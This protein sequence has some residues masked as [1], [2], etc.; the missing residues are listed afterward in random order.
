MNDYRKQLEQPGGSV[1][2]LRNRFDAAA[3][4]GTAGDVNGIISLLKANIE[5]PDQ[6]EAVAG[7]TYTLARTYNQDPLTIL[8][9]LDGW[10]ARYNG[11]I[12]PKKTAWQQIKDGAVSG[13]YTDQLGLYG[14]ALMDDYRSPEEKQMYKDKIAE[15]KA[16]MP[17]TAGDSKNL[18]VKTFTSTANLLGTMA[19]PL[20]TN[21]AVSTLIPAAKLPI[22]AAQLGK[23]IPAIAVKVAGHAISFGTTWAV[24]SEVEAGNIYIDMLE[25]GVDEDI[26]KKYANIHGAIAGALEAAPL[27]FAF[28]RFPFLKTAAQKAFLNLGTN[29]RAKQA[30]IKS[31]AGILQKNLISI[32]MN[33]LA[34]TSTEALQEVSSIAFE[35]K[36]ALALADEVKDEKLK[37]MLPEVY[38]EWRDLYNKEVGE[39]EAYYDSQ[40]YKDYVADR[41]WDVVVQTA[42][43]TGPISFLGAAG[44]TISDARYSS[45]LKKDAEN[46]PS[47][48]M[49]IK[50][51]KEDEKL[52]E[53]TAAQRK[54]TLGDI[55]D[56]NHTIEG[57]SNVEAAN[58][59]TDYLAI[60]EVEEQGDEEA[61]PVAT[62]TPTEPIQ[63][64]KD[65]RL[66]TQES[67]NVQEMADGSERHT[68]KLGSADSRRRY[69]RIEFTVKGD[70][71]TINDVYLKAGQQDLTGEFVTE[72]MRRYEGY[73]IE[74]QPTTE[75][76]IKVRDQLIQNNTQNPGKL[77]MFKGQGN[78]NETLEAAGYL[79]EKIPGLDQHQATV[80]AGLMRIIAE[81]RNKTLHEFLTDTIQFKTFAD[82]IAAGDMTQEEAEINKGAYKLIENGTKAIIYVGESGD[83]STL[84]HE[85]VHF[86]S[87]T[88]PESKNLA[89]ALRKNADT[90]QF[91]KYLEQHKKVLDNTG[92]DADGIISAI[93]EMSDNP[94]EWTRA[95]NEI[96]AVL[97]E[98][99]A[100][101]GR[102][103]NPELQTLFDKIIDFFMKIYR[104][105][106]QNALLNDDIVKAY[107][108]LLA[109]N[110][111]LRQKYEAQEQ[112]A[113][114]DQVLHQGK[115]SAEEMAEAERQYKE[116]E[117]Q[118][119]GTDQW[120]KAP[121]GQPTKLTER[122]WV[123]VRTPLFKAWF[124]DWENDPQ[125]ASKV[126]DEE[127]GEPMVVYHVTEE[128]FDTFDL[129][130][131]GTVT[132][133][134]ASDNYL[135]ATA[136]IG[137]WFNTQDDI[138]MSGD[139]VIASFLNI[140]E[141][142]SEGTLENLSW[143]IAG[144]QD[145]NPNEDEYDYVKASE[146]YRDSLEFNGY[147]GVSIE[148]EEF[149]GTSFVAL[150]PT[151]IK[152][153][154]DN[155]GTFSQSNP[156][157]LFQTDTEYLDA[158][159]AGDMT[160]AQAMVDQRAKE[161]GYNSPKLYHGTKAFGFTE[162][163][164]SVS[165]DKFTFWATDSLETAET[166][167][168]V[169][170]ATKIGKRTQN[171]YEVLKEGKEKVYAV[172]DKY[173][174]L[175]KRLNPDY[176][177]KNDISRESI[178]TEDDFDEL[179]GY[180]YRE[181]AIEPIMDEVDKIYYGFTE[182]L[183]E[184]QFAEAEKTKWEIAQEIREAL[185]DIVAIFRRD[186]GEGNYA[187]YAK[188]DNFLEIDA[189]GASW[190]KINISDEL[191]E[192]IN[193]YAESVEGEF[194]PESGMSNIV[195]TRELAQVAKELGYSGVH[196]KD[197]YDN[198]GRSGADLEFPA[199]VYIFFNPKEDVK[200]AD[201][202][203][204]D[205][206]GEVIPLSE[207]F[208]PE[209]TEQN[210]IFQPAFHGSGASF[211]KFSTD[212]MGTGEGAQ[213]FGWGIYFSED[214]GI[215][216]WYAK[217]Y[218]K[219]SNQEIYVNGEV[220]DDD[221]W[222]II[223]DW[224]DELKA[225]RK[226]DIEPLR[227]K[228][229]D[230]LLYYKRE[231][232]YFK[233][234]IANIDKVIGWLDDNK[235]TYDQIVKWAEN[236][237]VDDIAKN[238]VRQANI[239]CD[240]RAIFT[241]KEVPI[242]YRI[243]Y[244]RESLEGT[245]HYDNLS[246]ENFKEKE[247]QFKAIDEGNIEVKYA[248]KRNLYSVTIPDETGSN[249]LNW[250]NWIGKPVSDILKREVYNRLVADNS[251]RYS[252]E[253][254]QKKLKDDMDAFFEMTSFGWRVY[255][256][257]VDYFGSPENASK[258]LDSVGIIGVKYPAGAARGSQ[259]RYEGVYNYVIF[260][261]D[262]IQIDSHLQFQ[263]KSRE[264][265]EDSLIADAK[266]QTLDE[267]LDYNHF[268]G[269][270]D[271]DD[272]T[273]KAIWEKANH[274][275]VVEGEKVVETAPM[276]EEEKD[277]AFRA[278][279]DT[280]EGVKKFIQ[281][282]RSVDTYLKDIERE[283]IADE[284][285]MDF[286]NRLAEASRRIEIEAA[287]F[288]K[289]LVKN[290]KDLSDESIKKV[291][292]M[293]E[294][295]L[296]AYRDL[297]AAA[298]G[299]ENLV[300][301]TDALPFIDEPTREKMQTMS[302]A[303]KRRLVDRLESAELK[304]K[305]LQGKET[306]EGAAEKV[307]KTLD[308]DIKKL[309]AEKD[310]LK[311]S[312]ERKQDWL[313]IKDRKLIKAAE[314]AKATEKAI[315]KLERN[316]RSRLDA[317]ARISKEEYQKLAGWKD[318]LEL[319]QDDVNA[320]NR[321]TKLKAVLQ[322]R[323]KYREKMAQLKQK[324]KER[325]FAK[326]IHDYKVKLATYIMKKP[327][328]TVNWEQA[329]QI[330]AIQAVFG[331]T[332]GYDNFY[333]NL[334]GQRLNLT[335]FR[336][337]VDRGE[338]NIAGLTDYQL[339][340][341]FNKSLAEY[342]VEELETLADTV[343]YLTEQ[344]RHEWQ[345]KV[346]QRNFEA[347][348]FQQ[349]LINELMASPRYTNAGDEPLPESGE[350][351]KKKRTFAQMVRTGWYKTL[352]MARKAQMIDGNRKATAYRLLV[353]EKR[354]MQE[355]EFL[356]I[357][358]RMQPVLKMMKDLGV[359]PQ[360]FYE[361]H[362]LKIGKKE[363]HY[364]TSQLIYGLKAQLEQRNLEAFMYGNLITQR[365][366]EFYGHND[367]T[368]QIIGESRMDDFVKQAQ[369]I[370]AGKEN[371]MK[372]A[373]AIWQ[374][375]QNKDNFSMLNQ[376]AID[377]YN[378]PVDPVAFYMPI[379]R[380]DFNGTEL[381]AKIADDL[382]NTNAGKGM[383]A[384]E[385]G[386]IKARL[387]ISPD[388]QMPVD[389]DYFKLWTDS[390]ED[391]EHFIA[392]NAYVRKLNRVFKT[393][394]SKDLR[395]NIQTVYG[396]GM[397]A[398]IDNYINEVANPNINTDTQGVNR[399]LTFL[400]GALYPAYLAFKSSSVI[401]Q[402]ITSPAPFLREVGPVELA[403]GLLQMS[404]HPF[405]TWNYVTERSVTMENRSMNPLI[406]EVKKA[407]QNYTDPKYKQLWHRIQEVGTEG[408][409]L[410]D[411]WSVTA[412]WLA[413]FKK[414]KN[415]Y[416][417]Q[418]M[419]DKQA[420][421]EAV[422]YADQVV[423]ET[424][425]TGDKTELAPLFKVGGPAWQAFTQFQVSLNVIWNNLTYD[426]LFSD[427]VNHERRKAMGTLIGY[428]LAGALLYSVQEGF[429]DDDDAEDIILKLLYGATTQYTSSIPLVSSNID[430]YLKSKM[431]GEAWYSRSS[432]LYPGLDSLAQGL[433]TGNMDKVFRAVGILSGAPVSGIKEFEHAFYNRK[434]KEWRF[435]PGAFAGRREK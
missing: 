230:Q 109:G 157:I 231:K 239:N 367:N 189:E 410:A 425:P 21:I 138:S 158:I 46:F 427:R 255:N 276:S 206:N 377:E 416:M 310:E 100:Q 114:Q 24:T 321:Q 312:L 115:P 208:N 2:P 351:V 120:L 38:S 45:Q 301:N 30:M 254:A 128:E 260:N 133:D 334:N 22:V 316:I 273:L 404:L 17:N 110:P 8:K 232:A 98:T 113:T 413:V 233:K 84:F 205:D 287:P 139:R 111:E 309:E 352:N 228:I 386:M 151:Q 430:N 221:L 349:L 225:A 187:L 78:F 303:E 79:K 305:I 345:A 145:Y 116:I 406:D 238:V 125:N 263:P 318:K 241:A 407:A 373:E 400:R 337:M 9:D 94:M 1:I 354:R 261:D 371:I 169:G 182:G 134:N 391:Q 289:N 102:T 194:D 293:V 126:V 85:V 282:L 25:N 401:L 223:R 106:K 311:A 259:N 421:R 314:E 302:I 319:L 374:D 253:E 32:P 412:G 219:K 135:K 435:Y 424:Q 414:K 353:E 243:K 188:T 19:R 246:I 91:R 315:N 390:V 366:K 159:K 265:I 11:S 95:Q 324:Q 81:G 117:A 75:S 88:S 298:S 92:L 118:Y 107:D 268:M 161:Q 226:G 266:G 35:K 148:D 338:I 49:F 185:E 295:N 215:A 152:S 67:L 14:A 329:E 275:E 160:K 130:K 368:L 341:Y 387:T 358:K 122:Q 196:I 307:I 59:D 248:P 237:D 283:G 77:Q 129:T 432:Q 333:I 181:Y 359:K 183:S 402:M 294:N 104:M 357:R 141:P 411:R 385:K 339:K 16:N 428:A 397:L 408:L 69:G 82:A 5:D 369:T 222:R 154:T 170:V 262:N 250:D 389:T 29:T 288:I 175:I 150:Q 399:F 58:L 164:P 218:T 271:L 242:E 60:N 202:V 15:L 433:A 363:Q 184:E 284:E 68:L 304:K 360:D 379:S 393:M 200:S 384:V 256:R 131:A 179:S 317:G 56:K 144:T 20:L 124:G 143:E 376:A 229:R 299:N 89:Q 3:T 365:E 343:R 394:G 224:K 214:K 372:V 209:H 279:I 76:Q 86:I 173:L 171:P 54:D 96:V 356:A 62:D 378:M 327:S 280:D 388:H 415:E 64:R 207:R 18:V 285:D 203:T 322:E 66:H 147:D 186:S 137:F 423:L 300:A 328:Q 93:K 50:F 396:D 348:Q 244:L 37:K 342:T 52:G 166:Y 142:K 331:R 240:N 39:R 136:H 153:A 380:K 87:Q 320:L 340:R 278:M 195:N 431:T 163:D 234:Q 63:R 10:A 347:R 213:A 13:W 235:K 364:T 296:T 204:Y 417:A 422:K 197:I 382:Y 210:L 48:E 103:F 403:K 418:G 80:A 297:Y 198:G 193:K 201:P 108:A 44:Q 97:G 395:A 47:K 216:R 167:S 370:L 335:A 270:V 344:G 291:R 65:H 162:I 42:L 191:L 55:Y 308:D 53:M 383:T 381:A 105:M 127:T 236:G 34:E 27:E 258:F 249:Y 375:W 6:A 165:D 434:N 176:F 247:K 33:V 72:L 7:M 12:Q 70:T 121:N 272:D 199:D 23:E 290:N 83:F 429:D 252:T 245:K 168:T 74:W 336:G 361:M 43:G 178:V 28:T 212:Y 57:V 306:Y 217:T 155:V 71:V 274:I 420:E 101:E 140:R 156:S 426:V 313:D 41:V 267:W 149:G 26:A 146:A 132:D 323:E 292:G 119:K 174:N 172:V 31:F 325:Q 123:Q 281:D 277:N 264:E 330:M 332:S 36:A 112:T 73:N 4:T 251:E 269:D 398:D 177:S 61:E 362:T 227:R 99:Y 392:S 40:D 180:N 192:K 346:D 409:E 220:I 419:E 51:H 211:D 355:A 326:K 286:L 190:N 90:D 405:E 257:L 350:S